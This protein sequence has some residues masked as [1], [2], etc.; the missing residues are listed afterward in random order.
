[1]SQLTIKIVDVD[2]S[3]QSVI[4]KC[5]SEHSQKS[6]DDY[7]GLAFQ[8]PNYDA[9]NPEQF[10]DL[11]RTQ[12]SQIVKNRDAVENRTGTVDIA[13]WNGYTAT[14]ESVE[15]DTA[16]AD[17]FLDGQAVGGLANPEV[18]L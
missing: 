4:V 6:I 15:I 9:I 7:D 14:V 16:I 11:I 17:P 10:I 3:T 13:S 18:I 1:M 5:V 12:L 2:L 8:V